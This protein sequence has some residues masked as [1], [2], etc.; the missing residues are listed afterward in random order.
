M[1]I[2]LLEPHG[3]PLPVLQRVEQLPGL[4]QRTTLCNLITSLEQVVAEQ[5][6][7]GCRIAML[8]SRP[9]HSQLT[10]SDQAWAEGLEREAAQTTLSRM[11]FYIATDEAIVP[12][13]LPLAA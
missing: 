4:P 3:R 9:G 13:D 7:D 2:L 12:F 1:W 8:L 11:P 6:G 10:T 5:I